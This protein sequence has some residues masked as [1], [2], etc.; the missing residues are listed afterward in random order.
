MTYTGLA[1][2]LYDD[3]TRTWSIYWIASGVEVAESAEHGSAVQVGGE[4][5][6][7]LAV[8]QALAQLA[9]P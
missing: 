8:G 1:L 4:L 5:V 9:L 2:R 3:V 7:V 6:P